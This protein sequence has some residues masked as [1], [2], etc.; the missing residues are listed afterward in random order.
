MNSR[1]S[2]T[3]LRIPL[4]RERYAGSFLASIGIHI[5]AVMLVLFGGYLFPRQVVQIGSGLGGGMG[6]DISTVGVIDELSGGTGMVKP[7]VV[8]KPPALLEEPPPVDRSKAVPIPQTI[9]PR[10][11]KP[12]PAPSK[13]APKPPSSNVIPTAPEPGSGGQEAVAAEAAEDSEEE[14]GSRLAVEPAASATTGMPGYRSPDKQQLD[15]SPEVCGSK[16]FQLRHRFRRNHQEH[17]EGEILR[18]CRTRSEGGRRH[19]E[20]KSSVRPAA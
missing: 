4:I 19:Q 10:K 14:S 17:Q 3:L 8:P 11:K 2:L 6:G 15:P 18:Q 5:L 9:E 13:P 20:F 1:S 16:S 7:S 12:A